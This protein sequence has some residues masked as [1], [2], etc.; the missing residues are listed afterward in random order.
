[1][2][3]LFS[4]MLELNKENIDKHAPESPGVII[5]Y[6]KQGTIE[7][8]A[9]ANDSLKSTLHELVNRNTASYFTYRQVKVE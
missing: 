6:D 4:R 2:K 1:M 5:L 3:D 7:H 8:L 9:V